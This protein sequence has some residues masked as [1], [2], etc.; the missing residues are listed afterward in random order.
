MGKKGP[1]S[2]WLHGKMSKL[3]IGG[4]G[5]SYIFEKGKNQKKKGGNVEKGGKNNP[6]N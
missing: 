3:G 4:G 6:K 5:Q 2:N 1:S